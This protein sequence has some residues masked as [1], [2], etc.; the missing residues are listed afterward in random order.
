MDHMLGI[1]AS[2]YKFKKIEIITSIIS[3]HNAV[4]LEINYTKKAEK[5]TKMWRL[6]NMLLN[7][8]WIIEEI[9]T[10]PTHMGCSKLRR[11]FIAMQAHLNKQDKTEISSVKIHLV[12]LEKEEQ[13]K[14]KVSRRR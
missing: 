1:K 4:K 7:K 2:L 9:N 5:G 6:N 13:T 8:Q 14:P 3:D 12:E 10:M 11:K